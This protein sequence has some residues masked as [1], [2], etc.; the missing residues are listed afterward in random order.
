[1]KK[2]NNQ[3]ITRT[4][5]L[6]GNERIIHRANLRK[7]KIRRKKIIFRT[8]LCLIFIIAG[9]ILSLTMFF[10]IDKITVTGDS[11]YS[12][13]DVIN[14]SE[15][16]VGDNL[17]FL[18]KSKVNE[19]ITTKLPY[20]GSVTVKRHLPTG[21]E[22][23]LHK[24]EAVY[25]IA[26]NGYFTLLD[27]NTKVLEKDIE[28]IGENITLLNIGDIESA[29]TGYPI[30]IADTQILEK[31]TQITTAIKEC[32]F[33]GISSIDLTDLYNIKLT[34]RG[35][36]VLELGETNKN[37]MIKKLDFGKAAVET[38]NEENEFYKGTINLKVDGKGYWSEEVPTTE[39]VPESE[40]T[41]EGSTS[42]T[43]DSASA[44]ENAAESTTKAA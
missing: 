19:K 20:V 39:P 7:K 13:D 2:T 36:I 18:S 25:A 41:P 21:I 32:G 4:S 35:R 29:E 17:I 11:I 1:M 30:T 26:S 37:N 31:L 9:I 23:Q 10:N 3:N 28:Y 42:D 5:Q 38:Q 27:E 15:V 40:T 44:S 34:Y 16:L 8:V 6:S 12:S 33:D 14:A 43:T 22:L 24:T